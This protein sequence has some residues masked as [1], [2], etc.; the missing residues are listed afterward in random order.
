MQK[1][2]N[3][4][5]YVQGVQHHVQTEDW[6]FD[7]PWVVT[8]VF[9]K[10]LVVESVKMP[11]SDILKTGNQFLL[12]RSPDAMNRAIRSAMLDQHRATIDKLVAAAR[13]LGLEVSMMEPIP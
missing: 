7:N 2:F 1:G 8:R 11:Y 5:V 6:G 13:A 4:D 9:R 10:G 12:L 3:S